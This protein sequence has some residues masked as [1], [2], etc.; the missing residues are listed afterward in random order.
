MRTTIR[1]H[2]QKIWAIA[3]PMMLSSVSVPL[4]GLVDTA[5]LGHLGS[6][7]FLGAVAIGA[8]II[9]LMYWSFGFL[10]MGTTSLAARQ[11]GAEMHLNEENGPSQ[12]KDA[13]SA[14]GILFRALVLA[15][16]LGSAVCL[17]VPLLVDAVLLWMHSSAKVTP[18]AYEYIDIRRLSAPAVFMTFAIS[19]WLIGTQ[20]TR[21]ALALVLTTNSV[22][23]VLDIIFIKLLGLESAGAAW[24]TLIAESM[25]LMLGL[26]LVSHHSQAGKPS[27]WR[28]WLRLSHFQSM[29]SVNYHLLIRT[30]L[31]LFVFNFFTAQG[32]T[33]GDETLAANAILLQ[34]ILL[35]AFVLD[36]FSFAAEALCGEAYGGKQWI[37]LATIV[38]LCSYWSA[39]TALGFGIAYALFGD[40]II[41]LFSN[42]DSV[43]DIAQQYHWWMV[44]ITVSGCAAYLMDG[45]CIGIG[46][47][48]AMHYS[49]WFATV[50]I[51][52][53]AWWL[54]RA[55]GNHGLWLAFAMFTLARGFTLAAYWQGLR[56]GGAPP[57]NNRV[58]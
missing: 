3:W 6:A 52:L 23:I 30:V 14:D 48:R 32:S 24:A 22:N 49:M 37:T 1:G 35:T 36:G 20:R 21:S 18:L 44:G 12:A 41:A 27:L 51:F 40:A 33:M 56:I 45:V 50:I 5:L 7:Q 43:I 38:K 16:I 4:L 19:G 39:G 10:R 55:W 53:P 31:L 8:N 47:T 26:Y 28:G 42:V 11:H 13:R 34:L 57:L 46:K 29:L 9:G 15:A 25:G 17:T 2:N 58:K 54:G